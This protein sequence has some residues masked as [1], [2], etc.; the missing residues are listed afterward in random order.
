VAAAQIGPIADALVI[1]LNNPTP[2]WPT[3]FAASRGYL[4]M[5]L[6]ETLTGFT[7][8]ILSKTRSG[9]EISKGM[10]Q[11]DI[12]YVLVFSQR[13]TTP[14]ATS[15]IDALVATIEA[16]QDTY[17]KGKTALTVAG[18]DPVYSLAAGVDPVYDPVL[19]DEQLL[20]ISIMEITMGAWH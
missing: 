11:N 13:F 1:A 4:T 16:V 8:M 10:I 18:L 20:F 6:L 15:T 7:C 5:Q 2:A 9:E 19:L 17:L 14:P 3:P 12:V